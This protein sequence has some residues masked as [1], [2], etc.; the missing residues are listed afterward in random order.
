MKTRVLPSHLA[1]NLRPESVGGDAS[2]RLPGSRVQL[3]TP[4]RRQSTVSPDRVIV[5]G[6]TGLA[7]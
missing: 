2:A 7:L 1:E 6:A 4:A 5:R 3:I